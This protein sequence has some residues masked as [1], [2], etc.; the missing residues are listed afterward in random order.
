MSRT[1]HP[2][3]RPARRR[4]RPGLPKSVA[5]AVLALV[6]GTAR[7]PAQAQTGDETGE[8]GRTPTDPDR[9]GP[10][11]DPLVL[12][13]D[14]VEVPVVPGAD[15]RLRE[16]YGDRV[17]A[18]QF[19]VESLQFR[20]TMGLGGDERRVL[21][22]LVDSKRASSQVSLDL[23]TPL[24]PDEQAEVTRQ[25]G[26]QTALN[27]AQEEVAE[28]V[29]EGFAAVEIDHSDGGAVIV[30]AEAG[31]EVDTAAVE[32]LLPEGAEVLVREVPRSAD[33]LESLG[34]RVRAEVER[35]QEEGLGVV[36]HGADGTSGTYTVGVLAEDLDQVRAR[37]GSFGDAVV[38]E[39]SGPFEPA[40]SRNAYPVASGESIV[41]RGTC[42]AGPYV[43]RGGQLYVLTAGHCLKDPFGPLSA[44]QWRSQ[45][46]SVAFGSS[47]YAYLL[48]GGGAD[49]GLIS[50]AP[51]KVDGNCVFESASVCR[52]YI[53][54]QNPTIGSAN[55]SSGRT[56]GL[57]SGQVTAI[58]Q[59]VTW[60]AGY[61]THSMTY[62]TN[63]TADG[64]SGGPTYHKSGD[65]AVY[66][67]IITGS[68]PTPPSR[69]ILTPFGNA[70]TVMGLQ[71]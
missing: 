64:D 26:V 21:E 18:E 49:G 16:V 33:D 48:N 24:T 58:N 52:P 7:V 39:E 19:L 14:D 37:L 10:R 66:H 53:G 60:S 4:S 62:A 57:Q 40:H 68:G 11:E 2:S 25:L 65:K 15:A 54:W 17:D 9:V 12:T 46:E 38:I 70:A 47:A 28:A 23:L 8:A 42:T 44:T 27:E 13:A 41:L 3:H 6:A 29:G 32:S 63:S 56:S 67:G 51:G 59:S 43:Y 45:G 35:L 36:H 31:T 20:R 69:Q 34:E 22:L 5:A 1:A 71:F 61:T 50:V 55:V 30:S